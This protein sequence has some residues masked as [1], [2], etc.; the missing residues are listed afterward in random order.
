MYYQFI[1]E[2]NA[3]LL[4]QFRFTGIPNLVCIPILVLE[5]CIYKLNVISLSSDPH[6][7]SLSRD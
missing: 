7:V 2:D 3:A 5:C 4:Q 6:S 1:D